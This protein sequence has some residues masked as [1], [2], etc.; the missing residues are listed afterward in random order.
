MAP[1]KVE[2]INEIEKVKEMIMQKDQQIQNWKNKLISLNQIMIL[3]NEAMVKVLGVSYL[4]V[5]QGSTITVRELLMT[6]I[7]EIEEIINYRT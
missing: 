3:M 5:L 1:I 7:K 4:F 6:K 2:L